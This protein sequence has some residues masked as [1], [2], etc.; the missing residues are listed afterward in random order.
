[1]NETTKTGMK[2]VP[3]PAKRPEIHPLAFLERKRK[4]MSVKRSDMVRAMGSPWTDQSVFRI[5]RF[6]EKASLENLAL[7][8][9]TLKKLTARR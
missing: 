1:M 7:Y 9:E 3:P 6:P 8:I 4:E 2:K 5:E